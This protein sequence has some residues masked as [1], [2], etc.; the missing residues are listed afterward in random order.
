[1]SSL[2][3]I[4]EC[5]ILT[6]VGGICALGLGKCGWSIQECKEKFLI[7][8]KRVFSSLSAPEEYLTWVTRGWYKTV[9]SAFKVLLTDS[10]YDTELIETVLKDAFGPSSTM[11]SPRT[12]FREPR[13][14]VVVDEASSSTCKIL[15][16][17]NKAGHRRAKQ[18]NWPARYPDFLV[19]EA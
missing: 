6:L 14:A 13:V 3:P 7:L 10:I 8:T 4:F 16:T 17:Y 1:M 19:W 2:P 15:P 18:Y 11:V 5:Q 12:H 9:K